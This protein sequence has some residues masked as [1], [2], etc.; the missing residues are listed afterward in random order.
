[1]NAEQFTQ[2]PFT[3][4]KLIY[5]DATAPVSDDHPDPLREW[6]RDGD[7]VPEGWYAVRAYR[8]NGARLGMIREVYAAAHEYVVY[9]DLRTVMSYST[10]GKG[11]HTHRLLNADALMFA[12][13]VWWT[14]SEELACLVARQIRDGERRTVMRLVETQTYRGIRSD[15]GWRFARAWSSTVHVHE[16]NTAIWPL[17]AEYRRTQPY[18]NVTPW[19]DGYH[20]LPI[21]KVS[22]WEGWNGFR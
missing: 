12:R 21:P 20:D 5:L 14:P 1:M 11:P 17:V 4:E 18:K 3:L 13:S 15:P 22:T 7:T 16:P 9:V 10:P 6:V 19:E 2:D 8:R